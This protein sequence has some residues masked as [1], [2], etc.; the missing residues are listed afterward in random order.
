MVSVTIR[1]D[2]AIFEVESWDKL[3]AFRSRLE[4]PLVHIKTVYAEPDI[5]IGWLDS[6]KILGTSIPDIFRAGAFYQHGGFVF[7]D[8]RNAEN[9]IVVVL[10]HEHFS[11]LVIE[12]AD[13]AATIGFLRNAIY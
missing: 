2:T 10:E 7:W 6:L 11:K 12:V 4:I 5:A 3:W 9:T 1:G 8:V 13:P